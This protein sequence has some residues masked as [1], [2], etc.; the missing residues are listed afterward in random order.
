MPSSEIGMTVYV[1]LAYDLKKNIENEPEHLKDN[2]SYLG[3]YTTE[4]KAKSRRDILKEIWKSGNPTG[5]HR[6]EILG[7]DV[8][9]VGM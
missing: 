3:I 1:L 4:E 2:L 8:D 6:F 7:R 9:S 5:K